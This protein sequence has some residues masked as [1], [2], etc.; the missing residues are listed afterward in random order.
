MSGM[1][2]QEL[3][4][5]YGVFSPLKIMEKWAPRLWWYPAVHV[6]EI[7]YIKRSC[8]CLASDKQVVSQ[9]HRPCALTS[10]LDHSTYLNLQYNK[11]WVGP[12]MRWPSCISILPTKWP[13]IDDLCLDILVWLEF[14]AA[15]AILL[16]YPTAH[17]AQKRG[18]GLGDW[19]QPTRFSLSFL[20][21][22]RHERIR[23]TFIS[24]E[25]A[26]PLLRKSDDRP[27]AWEYITHGLSI[28]EK[29]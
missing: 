10:R 20:F 24:L 3:F 27:P 5:S 22:L 11:V 26:L 2:V 7:V 8:T 13:G 12:F 14:L 28:S 23:L 4:F 19:S 21:G 18:E 9:D 15:Q 29:K 16:P 6:P 1:N 17:K 25:R